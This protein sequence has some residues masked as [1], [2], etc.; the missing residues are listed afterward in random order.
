MNLNPVIKLPIAEL[1]TAIGGLTK[2]HL[3][4]QHLTVLGMIHVERDRHGWVRLTGTDLDTFLTF[5]A[6]NAGGSRK[7]DIVSNFAG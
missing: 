5:R 7:F 2:S 4:P 6:G 3:P 1:K